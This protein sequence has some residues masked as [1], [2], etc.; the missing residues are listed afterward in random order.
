MFDKLKADQSGKIRQNG[1]SSDDRLH[2][3][4]DIEFHSSSA[5]Q[6]DRIAC[7]PSVQNDRISPESIIH[8]IFCFDFLLKL[9]KILLY[10]NIL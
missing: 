2:P 9:L 5:I 3:E 8:F 1:R 4:Y 10:D 7:V 6:L